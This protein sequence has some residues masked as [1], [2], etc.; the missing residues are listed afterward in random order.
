MTLTSAECD[1]GWLEELGVERVVLAREL[2]VDEIA[3]IRSGN[4]DAA[5]GVRPRR[6]CAS[7]T[8]ASA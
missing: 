5:G 3:E 1:R 4:D 7:P 6:A 8:R 2:S